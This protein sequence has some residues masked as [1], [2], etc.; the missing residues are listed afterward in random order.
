MKRIVLSLLIAI[1]FAGCVGADARGIG[2][3]LFDGDDE[4]LLFDGADAG[5]E[6]V[7]P[8]YHVPSPFDIENIPVPPRREGDQYENPIVVLPPL[9]TVGE[10]EASEKMSSPEWTITDAVLHWVPPPDGPP[11]SDDEY[12]YPIVV[13]PPVGT[14]TSNQLTVNQDGTLTASVVVC[15][16]GNSNSLCLWRTY[17]KETGGDEFVP[18]I[19]IPTDPRPWCPGWQEFCCHGDIKPKPC[20]A[21]PTTSE[22]P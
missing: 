6:G 21:L 2:T 5:E 12:T 7:K 15:L 18:P 1:S 8:G 10:G 22:L 4:E 20:C 9:G 11:P 16:P 19:C 17:Q 14:Y 3:S 13:L